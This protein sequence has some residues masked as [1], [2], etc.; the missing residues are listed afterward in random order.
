MTSQ[1]S[2]ETGHF[3]HGRWIEDEAPDAAG[4]NSDEKVTDI[5]A[6]IKS[7]H[8]DISRVLEDVLSLGKDIVKT[9]EGKQ[10]IEDQVKKARADIAKADITSTLNHLV[11]EATKTVEQAF[12]KIRR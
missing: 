12:E 11:N 10:H 8:S 3:E 9:E 1:Q 4:Q 2:A 7:V 5:N 6:R